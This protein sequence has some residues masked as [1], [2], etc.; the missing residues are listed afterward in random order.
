MLDDVVELVGEENVVQ[1]VTDN[2]A[3]FKAAGELLMQKKGAFVLDPM[4]CTRH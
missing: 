4:C 3:N 1:V 2:A